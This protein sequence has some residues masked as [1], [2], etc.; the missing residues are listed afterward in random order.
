MPRLQILGLQPSLADVYTN[1]P[2][3]TSKKK[4]RKGEPIAFRLD[5]ASDKLLATHFATTPV[6]GINS[7]DQLARKLVIDV[8]HGRAIYLNPE[9]KF[10]NPQLA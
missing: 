4:V 8:I 10:S 6:I 5:P 9:D 7:I 1:M 3:M 2:I